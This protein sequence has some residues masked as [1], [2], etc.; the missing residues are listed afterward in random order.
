LG[1]ELAAEA[2][3]YEVAEKMFSSIRSTYPDTARLGY[4][5]ARVQ[6]RSGR[7]REAQETLLD[8][9]RV[10]H[11]PGD[12]YNL[13]GWCY[14]KQDQ[15]EEAIR[16]LQQ[17][18]AQDPNNESNYLD[19]GRIL[20]SHRHFPPALAIAK[21]NVTRHP[22]SSRASVM[23]GWVE[24]KMSQFTDAVVSY[25]QAVELDPTNPEAFRG[26]GVA[27]FAA[28]MIQ[29]AKSTFEEA[30]KQFPQDALQCQEYAKILFKLAEAGDQGAEFRAASLMNS[31][32]ALDSRLSEPHYYLGNLALRDAKLREAV[33]HLERAARLDPK[34]G[35]IHYALAR[36]YRRLGKTED[37]S[38]E[39]RLHQ[40][41]K[42]A[43]EKSVSALSAVVMGN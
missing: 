12:V 32:L 18:I 19:L 2:E 10:G 13:L 1:G 42:A 38:K 5:I 28:G 16:A 31:A 6:F 23:K 41:L 17:A 36:V 34:D 8:L 3:D 33:Q 11:V 25:R 22:R 9:T 35:K 15:P 26:L 7:Y 21:E 4:R 14:E 43:E 37:A 29:E 20:A 30:L 40:E 24:L 27:Q 39:L